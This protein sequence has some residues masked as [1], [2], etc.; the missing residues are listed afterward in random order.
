MDKKSTEKGGKINQ[1]S[2]NYQN[3][4][5]TGKE[6]LKEISKRILS[7]W[8]IVNKKAKVEM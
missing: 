2:Q 8:K 4:D 6:K 3:M 5:E 1:L 7:I